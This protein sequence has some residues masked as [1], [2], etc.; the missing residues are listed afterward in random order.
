MTEVPGPFGR[1]INA[2]PAIIGTAIG[3]INPSGG[4]RVPGLTGLDAEEVVGRV[5]GADCRECSFLVFIDHQAAF[6]EVVAAIF[7]IRGDLQ[8]PKPSYQR[9]PVHWQPADRHP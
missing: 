9:K 3:A 4:S 8:E 5:G 6:R 7:Q 1:L 2:V